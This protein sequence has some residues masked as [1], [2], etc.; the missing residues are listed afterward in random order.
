MIYFYHVG[1]NGYEDHITRNYYSTE[2]YTQKEFEN[3]LF[4]I[5]KELMNT[6]LKDEP[7]SVCFHNIFFN[8]DDLLLEEKFNEL[9]QEKGFHQ[10][11]NQLEASVNFTLNSTSN[12]YDKKLD[13]LFL[14]LNID[15]SCKQNCSRIP[16]LTIEDKKFQRKICGVSIREKLRKNTI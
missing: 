9:M 6:I 10:V 7:T 2:K 13:E 4:N 5:L 12:D 14:K 3:I 11:S 8:P 16:D 1:A 15:E